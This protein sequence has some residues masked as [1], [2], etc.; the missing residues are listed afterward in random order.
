VGWRLA[1][2]G[3]VLTG[4]ALVLYEAWFLKKTRGLP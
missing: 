2:A 4:I 3:S 1:G